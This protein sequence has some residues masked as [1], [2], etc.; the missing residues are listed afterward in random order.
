MP[1]RDIEN[2]SIQHLSLRLFLQATDF[3]FIYFFKNEENIAVL[4][5][6]NYLYL[7]LNHIGLVLYMVQC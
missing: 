1:F 7:S 3:L 4:R 5:G 2:C 6:S